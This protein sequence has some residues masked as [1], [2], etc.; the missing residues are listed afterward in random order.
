MTIYL[1]HSKPYIESENGFK[2]ISDLLYHEMIEHGE[3]EHM[4]V[5]EYD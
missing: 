4:E 2:P 1:I 3:I 5:I